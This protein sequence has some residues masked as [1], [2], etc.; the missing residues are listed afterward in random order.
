MQVDGEHLKSLRAQK[1]LSMR[2][3]AER[4][5]LSFNTIYKIERGGSVYPKS[6]R[7]LAVGL[8]VEV[9][10]LTMHVDKAS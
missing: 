8:G 6:I 2:E 3:L 9:E 10:E 7:K 1:A 4:A 5:E